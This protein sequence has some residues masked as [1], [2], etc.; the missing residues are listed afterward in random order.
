MN[1]Q[2]PMTVEDK[3]DPVAG[4]DGRGQP[5][6]SLWLVTSQIRQ[7]QMPRVV[8]KARKEPNSSEPNSSSLDPK[9]PLP[10]SSSPG[11]PPDSNRWQKSSKVAH[12]WSPMDWSRD[13][14]LG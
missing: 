2:S 13:A 4:G 8:A 7:S 5:R 1:D 11:S 14:L 6:L 12:H 3:G 10:H 9:S